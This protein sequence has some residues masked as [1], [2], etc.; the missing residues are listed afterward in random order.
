MSSVQHDRLV[1]R[2]DLTVFG[3][4]LGRGQYFDADLFRR[5]PEK[6]RAQMHEHNFV[7]EPQ[8]GD[9]QEHCDKCGADF[10]SRIYYYRHQEETHVRG[11]ISLEGATPKS[12]EDV[13]PPRERETPVLTDAQFEARVLV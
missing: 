8:P 9:Q 10:V 5:L 1:A 3:V 2:T 4:T 6:R 12:T 13:R 11:S 7:R